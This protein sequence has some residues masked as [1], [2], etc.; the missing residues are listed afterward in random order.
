M[1]KFKDAVDKVKD[2]WNKMDKRKRTTMVILLTGVILFASMY[3]Y[4]VKKTNYVVLFSNLE[5]EDAGY[6]ANDLESKK[7]NYKLEDNGRKILI[8]DKYVDKYR[9][10]LATEGN[11]PE[12]SSGF[13]IFDNI[14]LM[15][16][17]DDRKIMY[18]RALAGELQRSIMSLD[19]VES[20]KV[21][22]VMS[23][24]SIFE[25]QEKEAS[26]S[27]ILDLV[28]YEKISDS[29]ISGIAALVS[30]AV[31]NLP[32]EN[33]QIV[34][35]KG[36]LLSG[37]L[38]ENNDFNPINIVSQHQAI[39]EEFEKKMEANLMNLLGDVFGRDR[40]KVAINAD[41]D[42]DAEEITTIRYE[43]PVIR[44][45]QLSIS[46]ENINTREDAGG[47]IG[48][49]A[50]NV[51]E[52]VT[53]EGATYESTTNHELSNE[54]TTTIKAPGRINK[55][56]TSV[57]YDG[58]L[59]PERVEQIENIVATATGYDFERD[60]LINVAGIAFDRGDGPVFPDEVDTIPETEPSLLEKYGPREIMVLAGVIALIILIV[61]IRAFAKRRE[62][63]EILAMEDPFEDFINR[64]VISEDIS[65]DISKV[66][67][68][69]EVTIGEEEIK[70][71]KYAKDN[72]DLAADLI[73]AWLKD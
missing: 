16:T 9:L 24:K 30:G 58:T 19:A 1:D 4:F 34:D 44:S 29:T 15:A 45:Q 18:Q 28:P 7:I 72:P 56:T 41:L 23:E 26:A 51:I 46:G 52:T 50:S 49:N 11:M 43:D 6:I 40:I 59:S 66:E 5:L 53:G 68:T 17:D 25:T 12:S 27:V 67:E 60:D 61:I 35:S 3:T 2:S 42:F 54:T 55:M 70:A 64:E 21:H 48:D 39:K 22:L 37:I 36:N 65:K 31:D 71:K 33:I 8:D 63:K 73:R 38:Q 32:R 20:A 14:G 13:E 62:E 10:E 47:S 69:L 57:V